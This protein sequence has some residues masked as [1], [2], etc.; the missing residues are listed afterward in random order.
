MFHLIKGFGTKSDNLHPVPTM[1]EG[2]EMTLRVERE[3]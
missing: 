2:Q 3:K 1:V